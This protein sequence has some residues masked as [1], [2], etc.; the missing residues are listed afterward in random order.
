M[1]GNS[2]LHVACVLSS[3]A[4]ASSNTNTSDGSPKAAQEPSSH[5]A[6]LRTW[7][8]GPL[9]SGEMRWDTLNER[10]QYYLRAVKHQ[11]VV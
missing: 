7:A 11:K 6:S 9:L 4:C 5:D 2:L 3:V 8:S 10:T 1:R